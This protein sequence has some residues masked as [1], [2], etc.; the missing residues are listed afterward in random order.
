MADIEP[1]E[2]Y[3]LKNGNMFVVNY[4]HYTDENVDPPVETTNVD[5]TDEITQLTYFTETQVKAM[6]TD[7]GGQIYK[8][9]HTYEAVD[10][11]TLTDVKA[12]QLAEELKRNEINNK[13]NFNLTRKTPEIQVTKIGEDIPDDLG[14][15]LDNDKKGK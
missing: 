7:I 9:T 6:Q 1:R 12:E 15:P 5:F 13:H 2:E 10:P 3:I 4:N 14:I 11:T 8:V